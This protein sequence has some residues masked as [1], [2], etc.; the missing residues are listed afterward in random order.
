ME[1]GKLDLEIPPFVNI[2][3]DVTARKATLSIEDQNLKEQKEMWGE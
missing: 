2:D 1:S 3:H